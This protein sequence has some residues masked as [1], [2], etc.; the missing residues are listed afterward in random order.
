[1]RKNIFTSTVAALALLAL[2]GLVSALAPS[3]TWPNLARAHTGDASLTEL[4]VTAGG[5]AQDL[6]PAFSSTVYYYTVHVDD[7]VTQVTVSGMAAE[8]GTVTADQQVTL[9]VLGSRSINLV[10]SHTDSGRT[11]R[12]TYTVFVVRMGTVATDRAA[13]MALYNSTNGANWTKNDNWDSTDTLDMWHGV[14][15]DTDNRVTKLALGGNVLVGTMPAAL[16]NLDQLTNLKLEGNTLSGTIPDLSRLAKLTELTLENNAL[17]GSI[18]ASLGS[19]SLASLGILVLNNNQLTGE[20][21]EEL[22]NLTGL[23]ERLHLQNNNLSGQIP[24]SLG[25]LANLQSLFLYSNNLSGE[26]PVELGNLSSL[27]VLNLNSNALSGQV[28]ASLGKLSELNSLYLWGNELSGTIPDSLDNLTILDI[29][30]NNF[31]GPLPNLNSLPKLQFAYLNDNRFSGPLPGLG[32]LTALKQLKLNG[33]NL[34]GTIPD[35]KALTSL[36]TLD[37]QNNNFSGSIPDLSDLTSL[38]HLYLN[39]NQLSGPFPDLT[40]LTVLTH[41]YLNNN[42]LSGSIPVELKALTS[43]THLE[44]SN[45]QLSGDIPNLKDL[46]SLLTMSLHD[47]ML[48]GPVRTWLGL[49]PGLTHLYLGSNQLSGNFPTELSSITRLHGASF[50]NNTDV[51]G[52]PSLTGCVP[53]KLRTLFAEVAV[54]PGVPAQDFIGVDA[55]KDGDT[56]DPDDIPGLNLPFCMMS[57]LTLSE[58]TL[59]PAFATGTSVYSASVA[60]T[61]VSTIVTATVDATDG[62]SIMNGTASYASGDPVL[63]EVGLNEI[64]ITVTPMEATPTRTYTVTILRAGVDDKTTLL[65][66]YNSTGGASWMDQTNWDTTEPLNDWYGVTA[67]IYDDVT[68]LDLSSNNLSGTIPIVLGSLTGLTTLDL[69]DNRLSGTITNLSSLTSLQD[70]YLGDNQLSGTIPDWLIRHTNLEELSLQGN[71]LTGTIPEEFGKRGNLTLLYLARNQLSGPIPELLGDLNRLDAARF[72]GNPLTG[73]VPDGLRYLVTAP[74]YATDFPAQDFVAA[75]GTPGLGLPFCTLSSLRLTDAT[76]PQLNFATDVTDYTAAVAHDV[77]DTRVSLFVASDASD[78]LSIMKGA[79]TYTSGDVVLLDVGPNV[80]TIVVTPKDS[81]PALPTYTVTVTRAL[82][83]PPAFDEGPA[84]TRGV[85]ENTEA[86]ENIGAPFSVT[87]ADDD[88]LTYSLDTVSVDFFDIDSSSGEVQ[89]QTKAALDYETRTSYTVTVSV[90]DSEDDNS[91]TDTV[92]DNTITVTVL[93]TNINEAPVFPSSE[94]GRRSVDENTSA[95][96][97]IGAPFAATDDDNDPLTYSLD[98][99]SRDN[100][101]IVPT[102]GQLRTKAALNYEALTSYRVTVMAADPYS[103]NDTTR[104]DVTI[105]VNNVEE[106]GRVTLM[107]TQPIEGTQLT[108]RLYEPDSV[109]GGETWLW[110]SSPNVSSSWTPISG[111]ITDSYTP[112]AGDVGNFLRATVSYDDSHGPSK[113]AQAVSANRVRAPTGT[114]ELPEFTAIEAGLHDVDENTP[115]GRDIGA[116]VTATDAE[117]DPLTYS[118]ADR[119][120]ATFDINR[121][122]G[123]LRTKAA[124]DYET[125]PVLTP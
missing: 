16:N 49:L 74:A 124:L 66:L 93:V 18:P 19:R 79:D 1:M 104:L 97:N 77:E 116:P 41:L 72:A 91:N 44:L 6:T 21:P 115:A 60:N 45:N 25:R 42:Q 73:C 52:N 109:D 55:N 10:A 121:N 36:T 94:T 61:V 29:R 4:T 80:I 27:K 33:N 38:T 48:T 119:N 96:V 81:A 13:L 67:D 47:N 89:L 92:I 112:V 17:N 98:A 106:A 75:V 43:L 90:S 103:G 11:T 14:T 59:D 64:T 34:S 78:T 86:G 51:D 100:F 7:S 63:L 102:T 2:V 120:V 30:A 5:T 31:D 26:I 113:S 82:N 56:D 23:T 71:G 40:G 99:T 37:L 35:L 9:P 111:G 58:G 39:N 69:S 95:G 114:N 68:G 65:A 12:Q 110:E 54:A 70:L 87:D 50:A 22:S 117:S 122:T 46:K 32:N 24:A 20:I 15:V 84:A 101:D 107:S 88:T 105:T 125:R 57:A 123:Q 83:A 76:P 8:D 28:P 62:L 85:T 118:L 53:L 108:A 3:I